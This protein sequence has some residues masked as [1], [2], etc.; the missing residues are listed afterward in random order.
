MRDEVPLQV[1]SN[2]EEHLSTLIPAYPNPFNAITTISYRL[3]H[4]SLVQLSVYA[5][6]GQKVATLIN[7]YKNVGIH[8]VLFDG[9]GLASGVYF[10]RIETLD[11]TRTGKML[12]VK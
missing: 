6:S 7:D 9:G 11:F 5:I 4:P 3:V 2:L 10:Y 12:L 8:D 1:K